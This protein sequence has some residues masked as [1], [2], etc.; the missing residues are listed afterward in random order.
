M[1]WSSPQLT[2]HLIPHGWTVEVKRDEVQSFRSI[3]ERI[4]QMEVNPDGLRPDE[5][6]RFV[7][8]GS[9]NYFVT[10]QRMCD[11]TEEPD[12]MD[13]PFYFCGKSQG[14]ATPTCDFG[15]VKGGYWRPRDPVDWRHY[16]SPGS[17]PRKYVVY[18]MNE[19]V[20]ASRIWN[21]PDPGFYDLKEA[22]SG[23][24]H[25]TA[26]AHAAAATEVV[27]ALSAQP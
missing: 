22:L 19:A 6:F 24:M 27:K 26:E 9:L 23:A 8:F 25:P 5:R 2:L 15:A 11:R 16:K 14:T 7:E 20:M 12:T 17:K 4:S 10:G 21:D 13:L 18:S 1:R 3:Y